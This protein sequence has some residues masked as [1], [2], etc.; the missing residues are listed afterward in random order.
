M[1]DKSEVCDNYVETFF[2]QEL[3]IFSVCVVNENCE[4]EI[5]YFFFEREREGRML[6]IVF[7][8]PLPFSLPGLFL[9]LLLVP[10][11]L[12]VVTHVLPVR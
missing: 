1:V 8:S 6:V 12:V 7:F 2:I 4:C 5:F 9:L 3:Y 11:S 10:M